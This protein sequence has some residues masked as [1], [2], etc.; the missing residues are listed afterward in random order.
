MLS[1]T[2][3]L[4]MESKIHSFAQRRIADSHSRTRLVH[5]IYFFYFS[6]ILFFF[7]VS[8]VEERPC[9]PI[10]CPNKGRKKKAKG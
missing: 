8:Y 1:H 7:I 2:C 3:G 4:V 10:Q 9:W 6:F 5:F